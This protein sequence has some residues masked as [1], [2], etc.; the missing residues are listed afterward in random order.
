MH[1]LNVLRIQP[2]IQSPII[3]TVILVLIVIATVNTT[4]P[5]TTHQHNISISLL[6]IGAEWW[7]T[8]LYAGG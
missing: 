5:I 3:I 1:L 2:L 4:N 7:Q 6:V 8:R